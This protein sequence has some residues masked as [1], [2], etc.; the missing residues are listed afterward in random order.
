MSVPTFSCGTQPCTGLPKQLI[1]NQFNGYGRTRAP[2]GEVKAAAIAENPTNVWLVNV[3]PSVMKIIQTTPVVTQTTRTAQTTRT[4]Q[5]TP[6]DQV[7]LPPYPVDNDTA[8][9]PV[10]VPVLQL[11]SPIRVVP[12]ATARTETRAARGS[13]AAASPRSR[14][15]PATGASTIRTAF[16]KLRVHGAAARA[17]RTRRVSFQSTFPVPPNF[18][19]PCFAW[20]RTGAASLF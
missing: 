10:S 9:I 17:R 5:D 13:A 3:Q 19:R 2:R 4:V 8:W 20:T 15:P 16:F 1:Q 14:A 7:A 11:V 12:T 18:K 6:V